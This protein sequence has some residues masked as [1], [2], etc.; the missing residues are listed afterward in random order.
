MFNVVGVA[1]GELGRFGK[2]ADQV[3]SSR[4]H[5]QGRGA[6]AIR[7]SRSASRARKPSSSQRLAADGWPDGILTIIRCLL[8]RGKPRHAFELGSR[9]G[10]SS[11]RAWKCAL[12]RGLSA[13]APA[14]TGARRGARR[15]NSRSVAGPSS[16]LFETGRGNRVLQTRRREW[17]GDDH[18]ALRRTRYRIGFGVAGDDDRRQAGRATRSL[19]ITSEPD[20]SGI[21]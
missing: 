21:A 4:H 6:L 12:R 8:R 9:R 16:G 13:I 17:L 20:I 15:A 19:R 11:R 7:L 1:A 18:H 5:R 3:C 14:P 10:N 2:L